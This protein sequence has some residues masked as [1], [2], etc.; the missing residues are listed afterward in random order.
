MTKRATI[1]P[2]EATSNVRAC[3]TCGRPMTGFSY[4][5][6]CLACSG[7][8]FKLHRAAQAIAAKRRATLTRIATDAPIIPEVAPQRTTL[9]KPPRI[10]VVQRTAPPPTPDPS[11]PVLSLRARLRAKNLPTW[12]RPVERGGSG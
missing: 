8:T 1:P 9:P 6:Y 3:P 2:G 5:P 4:G 11:R 12:G 7:T 10:I